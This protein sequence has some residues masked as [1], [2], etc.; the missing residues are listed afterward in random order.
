MDQLEETAH[1]LS[2][3]GFEAIVVSTLE[4]GKQIIYDEIARISPQR[5]S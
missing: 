2:K 3:H 5:V 1:N 4:E